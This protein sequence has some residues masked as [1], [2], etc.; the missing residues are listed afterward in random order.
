M[1]L[2]WSIFD[3]L[4]EIRSFNNL[5]KLKFKRTSVGNSKSLYKAG[6]EFEKYLN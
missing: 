6:I 5:S 2:I 1:Y 4:F 3:P